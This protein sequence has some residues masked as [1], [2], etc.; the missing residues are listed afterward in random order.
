MCG[1]PSTNRTTLLTDL[2]RENKLRHTI[3]GW[4]GR[5]RVHRNRLNVLF[6]PWMCPRA[7]G[8]AQRLGTN[9]IER[10]TSFIRP[11]LQRVEPA[12]ELTLKPPETR[13]SAAAAAPTRSLARL[14]EHERGVM[15]FWG[16]SRG[17]SI[18]CQCFCKELERF[19]VL[20]VP[21]RVQSFWAGFRRH[22]LGPQSASQTRAAVTVPAAA[23]CQVCACASPT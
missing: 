9:S 7:S 13:S 10:K 23:S 18:W 1:V 17:S 14:A 20:D 8:R 5:I 15:G 11:G 12:G 22:W 6:L 2:H 3:P 19:F 21:Q 4:N 16:F